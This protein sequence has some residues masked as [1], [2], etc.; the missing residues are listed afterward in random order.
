MNQNP[1]TEMNINYDRGRVPVLHSESVFV[2]ARDDSVVLDFAQSAGLAN[3]QFVVA[4]L[5]MS[6]D[7]AKKMIRAIQD[8]MGIE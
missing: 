7:Q 4:S 3:Q 2:T 1:T 8:A 5:G 6:R